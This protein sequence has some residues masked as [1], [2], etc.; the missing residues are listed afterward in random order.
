VASTVWTPP[1]LFGSRQ[2]HKDEWH[3]SWLGN[4]QAGTIDTVRNILNKQRDMWEQSVEEIEEETP[5]EG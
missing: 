3:I 4:S 1:K 2:R 5:Y